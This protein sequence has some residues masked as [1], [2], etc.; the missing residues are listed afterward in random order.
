MTEGQELPATPLN[1]GS[2]AVLGSVLISLLFGLVG[3]PI[4]GFAVL[5]LLGFPAIPIAYS[6]GFV[7]ALVAGL[8]F[9]ALW[10][11][12]FGNAHRVKGTVAI[13]V[14]ASAVA[15]ARLPD[16]SM[17][18]FMLWGGGFASLACAWLANRMIHVTERDRVR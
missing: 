2:N 3:P 1:R 16:Q 7:P 11:R 18:V 9:I 17:L 4:G 10:L 5:G 12:G 15:S 13:G 6:V 14:L 8:A